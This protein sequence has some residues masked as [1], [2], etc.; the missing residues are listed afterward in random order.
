MLSE[1]GPHA[2]EFDTLNLEYLGLLCLPQLKSNTKEN[3]FFLYSYIL[4]SE[5][6]Y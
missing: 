4:Q 3:F 1:F 6:L 5:M 2:I